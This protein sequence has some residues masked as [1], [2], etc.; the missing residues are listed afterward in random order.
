MTKRRV[1]K[2][3]EMEFDQSIDEM[4]WPIYVAL[5]VLGCYLVGIVLALCRFD[6]PHPLQNAMTW[7]IAIPVICGI[8]A[9]LLHKIESR[10]VR[11]GVLLS[12]LLS[13]IIHVTLLLAMFF[14]S[15]FGQL[16]PDAM[17]SAPEPPR[18]VVTVPDAPIPLP[19]ERRAPQDHE[20]P[21]ESG[22]PE[23]ADDASLD[24]EQQSPTLD[25]QQELAEPE[26]DQPIE[27]PT[28]QMRRQVAETAP[29]RADSQATISRSQLL[30]RPQ[31][32]TGSTQAE[33][34]ATNTDMHPTRPRETNVARQQSPRLPQRQTVEQPE[35][36][37]PDSTPRIARR[38]SDEAP[39][40]AAK[41]SPTLPRRFNRPTVTPRTSIAQTNR[42]STPKQTSEEAL[43]PSA[44]AERREATSPVA[45]RSAEQ[46]APESQQIAARQAP[47]QQQ[48]AQVN[49]ELAST[50]TPSTERTSVTVRPAVRS[51][52]S[53][54][55]TATPQ[56]QNNSYWLLRRRLRK[57]HEP[58]HNRPS[59]LRRQVHHRPIDRHQRSTRWPARRQIRNP[60]STVSS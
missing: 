3:V 20:R 36:T 35:S 4:L 17:V 48:P 44:T 10:I 41:P 55:S 27:E 6:D 19:P 29:R 51:D 56:R 50:L 5:V 54:A 16:R 8:S 28:P 57:S 46:P 45:E 33:Q 42:P 11:R 26:Q 31:V 12:A 38:Q 1:I 37:Q 49:P 43:A 13:L 18:E 7:L 24:P 47:R 52:V 53:E 21:V 25:N 9:I 60:R 58:R 59:A 39:T 15:I 32:A 14:T 34:P 30:T 22:E 40:P 23:E 2:K